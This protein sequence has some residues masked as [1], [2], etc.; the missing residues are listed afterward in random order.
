[1]NATTA[2]SRRCIAGRSVRWD[3]ARASAAY[4]DG[5]WVEDT[6]GAALHRAA[7]ATPDRVVLIDGARRIDCASLHRDAQALAAAM[8]AHLTPG[9]V[10]SFM[11]PNWHEAATIYFAA[12][13]AGMVVHPILP[14]LREHELV[15]ML[16]D[17]DCK[18]IFIPAEL[19]GRD[20]RAMMAD[21]GSRLARR[22]DIIVL[23]GEPAAGQI[24][25]EA[26][27]QENHAASLPTDLPEVDPDAVRMVLYTSGTTGTPKGVMHSQNSIH[28]LVRQLR[29]HWLVAPGDT[30]L[31]P[32]PISHIGGSIYAFEFPILLGTT[33]VLMERW[34][35]DEAIALAQAHRVTHT[36]GATP[37]LE[38][39]LAAA[40]RA[41]D[42]LPDLKV[43]ICGG[44]AVPPAL[45]RR[46]AAWFERAIV[47]RVYG[48]TEVPVTSIGTIDRDDVAHAALTDGRPGIASVKLAAHPAAT[49]ADEGEILAR[50]AQMLVGY[51]HA[52]DEATVFDADGYY[53]TG[54]LGRWV[55]DGFLVISGRAKD[56]IIR[57]GENI[58]PKEVED[59]LAGH[60]DIG[61]VAIVGVP[62]PITGERACAVV[63]AAGATP[64]DLGSIIAFLQRAGIASFKLPERLEIWSALPKNATGKVLKHEIR[65]TLIA[66]GER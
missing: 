15:F 48:S 43:F 52:E 25:F 49:D 46:A 62:H 12:T 59:A 4:R 20:F 30:F 53:R 61:D 19:R 60:P 21:I 5:W 10:V 37:F 17:I 7:A 32:S 26:L 55:D 45:I 50:G 16:D 27:R 36:A 18:M 41:G 22:P 51:V 31:V 34:D 33:A 29:E 23:R 8:L 66:A 63:V 64:P 58:S 28:A 6:L 54:D 56:I 1:M 24:G 47:T 35:A 11:L 39:L 3:D 42:R 40:R 65:A 2:A 57:N 38:Q 13:L 44:A 9:S 14:A